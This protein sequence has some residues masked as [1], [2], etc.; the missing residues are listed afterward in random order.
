MSNN[1]P[2]KA[3]YS[4]NYV[5]N[6]RKENSWQSKKILESVLAYNA[7]Y[8]GAKNVNPDRIARELA[9]RFQ[10]NT[11]FGNNPFFASL[12]ALAVNVFHKLGFVKPTNIV[13]KDLSGT[14]Y[15]NNIGICT[16]YP[17]ESQLYNKFRKN[18]PLGTVIINAGKNWG[19]SQSQITV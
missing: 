18:F 2:K 7:I 13:L 15:S 3:L 1:L 17:S 4:A 8:R 19:D 14:S 6:L 11:D 16:V 5:Q 10:I 12:A 9:S